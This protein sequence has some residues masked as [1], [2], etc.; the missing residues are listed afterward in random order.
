MEDGTENRRRFQS[1]FRVPS[2][3][4]VI[5]GSV[6]KQD[7]E[8]DSSDKLRWKDEDDED[9]ADGEDEDVDPRFNFRPKQNQ[10]EYWD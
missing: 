5:Q 10:Q 9:E 8:D 4:K 2:H 7:S 6:V 3:K 1:A